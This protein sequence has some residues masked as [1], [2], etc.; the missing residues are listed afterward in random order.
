MTTRLSLRRLRFDLIDQ[1]HRVSLRGTAPRSVRD[2]AHEL[3]ARVVL[4]MRAQPGHDLVLQL[5]V[6]LDVVVGEGDVRDLPFIQALIHVQ[7]S[8]DK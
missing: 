8:R 1:I 3:V 5:V 6:G 2:E 7:I 4:V